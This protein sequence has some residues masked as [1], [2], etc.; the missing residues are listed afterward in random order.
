MIKQMIEFPKNIKR[1]LN[2]S[3]S[4]AGC[5]FDG[6]LANSRCRQHWPVNIGLSGASY[7]L[8]E[9]AAQLISYLV[10]VTLHDFKNVSN[11]AASL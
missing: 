1:K 4:Q 8:L 9:Q 6:S 3:C 5:S 11:A 2:T 10:V 7:I